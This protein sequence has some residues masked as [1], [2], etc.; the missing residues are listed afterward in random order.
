MV[1]VY[2][3]K[4]NTNKSCYRA[5]P[6]PAADG[7]GPPATLPDYLRSG[8]DIVSVGINPSL[9]S[10]RAGYYF[11]N[12]RN[13]FWR[14]LN[15]S[16]LLPVRLVPGVAAMAALLEHGIG[17]TDVVKRP[18]AMAGD[19]RAADY[20][21]DVPL[22]SAK[23]ARYQPRIIWFQGKTACDHYLKYTGAMPARIDWGQQPFG[24]GPCQV[25]VTPS[26]S[27][28]NAVFS[29]ADL[30]GWMAQLAVLRDSLSP[31]AR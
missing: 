6:D 2:L 8:L 31:P 26:P 22:L 17:F 11:A 5:A 14:A 18:T 7:V 20:R 23:L 21:Q 25:F 1:P 3:I 30:A 13:R 10:V 19:L 4:R 24:L 16:G 29:L 9:S 12:P 27:P 28:A 15:D